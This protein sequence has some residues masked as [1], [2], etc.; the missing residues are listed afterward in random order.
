MTNLIYIKIIFL[1]WKAEKLLLSKFILHWT[2]K[3]IFYKISFMK[4]RYIIRKMPLTF[5]F[6]NFIGSWKRDRKQRNQT[7]RN[8]RQ[9]RNADSGFRKNSNCII[10]L[11]F[12][13]LH[14]YFF[15]YFKPYNNDN[16]KRHYPK[17]YNYNDKIQFWSKRV[18]ITNEV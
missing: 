2:F 10:K 16:R 12:C 13:Y 17:V 18:I 3:G 8:E 5:S 15:K 7:W 11:L 1:D 14:N 6:E 9:L 4:N